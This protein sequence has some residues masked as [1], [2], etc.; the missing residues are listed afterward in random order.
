[1]K[2]IKF[3][4]IEVGQ[5]FHQKGKSGP[6]PC[7]IEKTKDAT[8]NEAGRGVIVSDPGYPNNV[9]RVVTVPQNRN[10]LIEA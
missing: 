3:N 2:N 6:M 5:Q 9:G 8:H 1:M 10:C 4:K 7:L